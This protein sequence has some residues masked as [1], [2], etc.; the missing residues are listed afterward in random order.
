M[1]LKTNQFFEVNE[2]K[3]KS[4]IKETD[5]LRQDLE[6]AKKDLEQSLVERDFLERFNR[7]L[8]A[9]CE[10]LTKEILQLRG[11]NP[12][13]GKKHDKNIYTSRD[14]TESNRSRNSSNELVAVNKR[15][16]L[17]REKEE[18]SVQS[19]SR[20]LLK[21]SLSTSRLHE[22]YYPSRTSRQKPYKNY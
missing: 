14:E 17:K 16:D 6:K 18:N 19:S 10:T 8:K 15:K 11:S 7:N 21:N 13:D 2:E 20:N 22:D 12:C 3:L 4:I 5:R 1:E 9:Q